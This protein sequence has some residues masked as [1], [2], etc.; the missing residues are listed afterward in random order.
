MSR[1]VWL[2]LFSFLAACSAPR[3]SGITLD[4]F[5]RSVRPQD[6]LYRF[7]NGAWLEKTEIPDDK[8]N[9]GTFIAL[10]D[11]AKADVKA[12]IEETASSD[13]AA[14]T[15]A[16]KIADLYR[17]V[18]NTARL[19]EL[20][21][22]PL[23]PFLDEI[24]AIGDKQELLHW[25][26]RAQR[27]GV[28]APVA[29]YVSFDA[30][31]PTRYLPH[32]TQSGLGLPDRDYYFQQGD[33]FDALRKGYEAQ[34]HQLLKLANPEVSDAN[35]QWAVDAIVAI[36]T[37]LAKGSWTRTQRRDRDKTYNL[38]GPS[39]LAMTAK[40]V[41]WDR[42]LHGCGFEG[43]KEIVVRE[44]SYL[45]TFDN[46]LQA[47]ELKAWKV[48][49]V[50]HLVRAAAPSMYE[51]LD[52]AHFALY[53]R[54]LAGTPVQKPRWERAV[55]RVNS[56][57][58]EAVGQLYV[59][60]HFEPAAKARMKELVE[61]LRDAFGE[62]LADLEWMS[63]PTRKQ[64]LEK[65]RKFTPKIG[66]PDRWKDYSSLD[67]RPDDLLG[68]MH[69]YALWDWTRDLKRLGG[70]V[71]RDEWFMSPQTVN[72]YYNPYLNEIVF[73]AAILQPPFFDM[74]A[75]DAVNYGAIGAVIGHEMGHGFDDQGAKSD[76]DGVLRSWWT[77]KDL[78]EFRARTGRLAEQFSAYE[79]LKGER[80][81][82][83][84]TLGENIGDLGGLTIAWRAWKRSLG[85][86]DSPVLDGFTGAQ[87]FF[88]GWAQVW[89]R[90]YRDAELSRRLK[91]DP[92]S[93]SE[94]RTNGPVRNM[95]SFME[96]FGVKPGDGLYL[97]PAQR[98][99]IW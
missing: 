32:L 46:A 42:Y 92:H 60:R 27:A 41:A 95:P 63:E 79:P 65:L 49:A 1:Q 19:E 56:L 23:K 58:G 47:H 74:K 75:D 16:R 43:Q 55:G 30:K 22:A 51:A 80:V 83:K 34:M 67:I 76:G 59:A 96:A 4:N 93:P 72:A 89:A 9:Y 68:N 3:E 6:D 31:N 28:T 25:F 73:P 17:S 87:R 8:S 52:E 45:A 12:I 5:D 77:A 94:Y 97:P 69:R 85:D 14:G 40:N 98:A 11:Q 78:E 62:T 37:D 21:N 82:G 57:L 54:L 26:G 50:W 36:E 88:I 86:R 64:A 61:N 18:M 29:A 53:G 81:N 39:D 44:L 66:Y 33:R 99:S 38:L 7:V 90:K 48:Y 2:A 15:D 91:V 20:K 10:A 13:P 35:V 70:P 24:G 84:L 71:D